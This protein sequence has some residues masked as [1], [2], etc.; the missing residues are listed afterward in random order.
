MAFQ[1]AGGNP[2]TP[3]QGGGNPFRVQPGGDFGAG[4]SGLGQTLAEVGREK[5]AEARFNEVQGAA[6]EAYKSGDP[7]IMMETAIKYPELQESMKLSVGFQNDRSERAFLD[8][9]RAALSDPDNAPDHIAQGIQR[10][11]DETDGRPP[12]NML[13]MLGKWRRDPES[14]ERDTAMWLAGAAPKEYEA[15]L[16]QRGLESTGTRVGAQEI[17]PDG[18]IIQST[19]SGPR[20][21][22]PEGELLKGS[23]AAKAIREARDF[24]VDIAQR[25]SGG[26]KAGA[27]GAEIG[28]AEDLGSARGEVSRRTKMAEQTAKAAEDIFKQVDQIRGTLPNYDEALAAIDEGANIGKIQSMLPSFKQSTIRF[29]NAANRLGLDVVSSVTFG[30]LSEGELKLAMET[31]MPR[32]MTPEAT[33]EWITAKRD[34]QAK[35]ADQMEEAAL[36][37]SRGGTRAEWVEEQRALKEQREG[38]DAQQAAGAP[39]Q[40]PAAPQAVNWSDL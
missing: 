24:G 30:A 16:T 29:E 10:V 6:M 11:T 21:Y 7:N 18:G 33:R 3:S 38:G 14:A 32:G 35:L 31:A 22:S 23:D 27:L 34:A 9:A 13:T 5:K 28:L 37:F 4:L 25:T 8:T 36:F 15:Y 17:L 39:A 26:R 1:Y 2:A 12:K 20:V 19:S 40:N